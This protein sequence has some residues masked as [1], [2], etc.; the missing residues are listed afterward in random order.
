MIICDSS[1]P[2]INIPTYVV[3]ACGPHAPPALDLGDSIRYNIVEMYLCTYTC[4]IL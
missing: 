2:K 1:H 3:W 4:V